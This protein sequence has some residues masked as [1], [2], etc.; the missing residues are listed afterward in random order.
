M[1]V[2][3]P[4]SEA[5]FWEWQG[6][7]SFESPPEPTAVSLSIYDLSPAWTKVNNCTHWL[8][9]GAFHAGIE[10]DGA[11]A[12]AEL[13][14]G[15]GVR[16]QRHPR[17]HSRHKFRLSIPLGFARI[18]AKELKLRVSQLRADWIDG[19]YDP[20]SHNCVHFCEEAAR[21]LEVEDVPRWV[22]RLARM[23]DMLARTARA[24]KEQL[25]ARRATESA[26]ESAI[27]RVAQAVENARDGSLENVGLKVDAPI[28]CASLNHWLGWR[29][30]VRRRTP[31]S[32][33]SASAFEF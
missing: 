32:P 24:L 3:I 13:T 19:E 29:F 10:M 6:C 26:T 4:P 18:S 8:G 31:R 22:N 11:G 23:L 15:D 27:R 25:R 9:F 14:Y 33:F 5:F 21:A 16:L 28:Q 30:E 12:H 2:V 20:L 17:A 1:H 7:W